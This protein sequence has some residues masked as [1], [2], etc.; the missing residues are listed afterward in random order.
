MTDTLR[1]DNVLGTESSSE[2]ERL[3]RI[4]IEEEL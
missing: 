2:L 1:I 4:T 3:N